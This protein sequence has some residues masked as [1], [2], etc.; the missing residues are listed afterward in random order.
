LDASRH[1]RIEKLLPVTYA[2]AGDSVAMVRE[3]DG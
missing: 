2:P 3:N 1:V